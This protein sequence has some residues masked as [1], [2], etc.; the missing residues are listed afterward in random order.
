MK[1]TFVVVTP[2]GYSLGVYIDAN[3][4]NP[5]R[6]VAFP[7]HM[8]STYHMGGT[9]YTDAPA[10][11]KSPYQFFSMDAHHYD[12]SCPPDNVIHKVSDDFRQR[13]CQGAGSS[14]DRG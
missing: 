9:S 3:I 6:M 14:P 8:S 2:P 1:I 13:R 10:H 12:E 7:T 4:K 5:P 11:D